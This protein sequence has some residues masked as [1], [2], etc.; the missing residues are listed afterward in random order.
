L[1]VLNEFSL[2]VLTVE[3]VA[4]HLYGRKHLARRTLVVRLDEVWWQ[5][6]KEPPSPGSGC[7]RAFARQTLTVHVSETTI[8]VELGDGDTHTVRRTTTTTIKSRPPRTATK[9]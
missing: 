5:A 1:S 7:G 4:P 8:T 9:N 6:G 2:S 3:P